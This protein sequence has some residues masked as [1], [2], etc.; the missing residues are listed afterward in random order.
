MYRLKLS[1][2]AF[3][4]LIGSVMAGSAQST[5]RLTVVLDFFVNPSQW[6]LFVAEAQGLFAEV[7]LNVTIQE[8]ADPS[9]PPQ[10]A[11]TGS[12]DLALTTS[13]DLVIQRD[14]GLSL[15]AVGSLIQTPLGGL[16]AL[17]SNGIETLS[18]LRGKSIGFA[19]E[20]EEPALWT[21][22]MRS[23]G[24]E[25]GEYELVNIGFD[26][27]P[28]LLSGQIDAV[29]GFRNFEPI[30]LGLEGA[31]VV[32]FPFEDHGIPS[33]WQLVF[34]ANPTTIETKGD[35]IT[36]FLDAVQK[37][38]ELTLRDP[39]GSLNDFFALN[40]TLAANDQRELNIRS[41]LATLL[42]Y[43]GAPCHND[44]Q[45]WAALQDFI[46][47]QSLIETK[48]DLADLFNSNFLPS[49]CN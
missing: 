43:Q 38:V 45:A 33:S 42:L 36:R 34:S 24:V 44:A 14:R 27:I 29:S 31:D 48:A 2:L 49:A 37:A 47:D 17:R 1:L 22:M 16:V 15:T 19:L 5:D 35:E 21:A 6:P 3:L 9:D 13:F 12:V 39:N 40:P 25:P 10:L 28:L 26:G 4:L 41:A 18:D 7:G 46:F 30:L 20:P 11:A 8:P 32:F 23:V